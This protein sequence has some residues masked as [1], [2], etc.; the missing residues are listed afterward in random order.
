MKTLLICQA[1]P[2]SNYNTMTVNEVAAIQDVFTKR[3]GDSD[4]K[5]ET[6]LAVRFLRLPTFINQHKPDYIHFAVP[7]L[8]RAAIQKRRPQEEINADPQA[9]SFLEKQGLYFEDCR[10]DGQ[11]LRAEH[12]FSGNLHTN[13]TISNIC[14]VLNQTSHE[15]SCVFFSCPI[16]FSYINTILG[17][18]KYIIGYTNLV[19]SKYCVLFAESFYRNLRELGNVEQAFNQAI[20]NSPTVGKT[21]N[22]GEPKLITSDK[23]IRF[24][25]PISMLHLSDLHFGTQQQA[26][27]WY[28]QLRDDLKQLGCPCPDTLVVSGD[29]GNRASQEEYHAA[30]DFLNRIGID[31]ERRLIVPGNHDVDWIASEKSY[32]VVQLAPDELKEAASNELTEFDPQRG[33][34]F[35]CDNEYYPERLKNFSSFCAQVIGKEYPLD[36]ENQFSIQHIKDGDILVLGLNSA[37]QIDHLHKARASIHPVALERALAHI[38]SNPEFESSIKIAVWHHPIHYEGSDRI[39]LQHFLQRL[40]VSGFRLVLHGHIHKLQKSSYDYDVS[41][42][43]ITMVSAGTFGAP[44][45]EWSDGVPLQYNLIYFDA[46]KV[47]IRSRCRKDVEGAWQAEREWSIN[48]QDLL[49]KQS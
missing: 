16:D 11:I 39:S 6:E 4:Y 29:I 22:P 37:W 27:I 17:R 18:V 15:I 19:D 14:E 32:P 41:G 12:A 43:K 30:S 33:L 7:G 44:T 46:N 40:Y 9:F 25:K 5:L 21:A 23:K 24:P 28:G 48:L 13:A 42:G 31:N 47:T 45:E 26:E 35:Y 3:D 10:K 49:P 34:Y 36:S 2:F 38:A 8:N 20:T 1:D